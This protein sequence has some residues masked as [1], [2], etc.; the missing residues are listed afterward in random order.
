MK[1][2]I[3]RFAGDIRRLWESQDE[4]QK[5]HRQADFL[6]REYSAKLKSL[7]IP[8]DDDRA[9][10]LDSMKRRLEE[11][12]AEH[13]ET[14]RQVQEVGSASLSAGL[15]PIFQSLSGFSSEIL[16]AYEAARI[17]ISNGG[18]GGGD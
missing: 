9:A 4:E 18:G 11:V 16:R 13:G 10:D 14:L 1:A 7:Q 6:S 15:I 8:N 12:R 3:R 17:P 5:L 2:A